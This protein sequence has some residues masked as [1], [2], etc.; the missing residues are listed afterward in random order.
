MTTKSSGQVLPIV[1]LLMVCFIGLAALAIDG[2]NA[3]SQQRRMQADLDMAVT[4]AAGELEK[5]ITITAPGDAVNLLVQKGHPT[6]NNQTIPITLPPQTAPYH[7]AT[8]PS[9]VPH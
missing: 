5:P 3:L 9:P 4:F 7:Q 2:S 6:T 1:A 8:W